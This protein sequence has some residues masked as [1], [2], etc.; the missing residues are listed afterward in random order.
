MYK[1]IKAFTDV[2]DNNHVYL[3]GDKYPREGVV[4][5]E[6]RVAELASTQNRRGE[7]LIKAQD[8]PKSAEIP[9]VKEEKAEKVEVPKAQKKAPKKAN[10]KE[11]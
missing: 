9:A 10:K 3:A 6:K 4:A 1:V 5:D 11:K 8:T 2:Q 7:V